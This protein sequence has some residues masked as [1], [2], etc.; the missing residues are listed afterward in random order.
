VVRGGSYY[1]GGGAGYLQVGGRFSSFPYY[2][3]SSLG[4]RFA[5]TN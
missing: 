5:R 1:N 2:A 4:F 3:S